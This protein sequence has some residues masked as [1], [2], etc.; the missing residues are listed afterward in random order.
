MYGGRENVERVIL[1]RVG[2]RFKDEKAATMKK[3]GRMVSGKVY[4]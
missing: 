2:K 4:I 3:Y 1:A